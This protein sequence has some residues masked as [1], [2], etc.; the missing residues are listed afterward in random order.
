MLE[1][2]TVLSLSLELGISTSWLYKK[3]ELDE[4]PFHKFGNAIRFTES[5]VIEIIKQG[6]HKPI[7]A[8]SSKTKKIEEESHA[9]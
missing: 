8:S 7:A 9:S 3:V 6:E 4:I 5:D 2:R 1:I